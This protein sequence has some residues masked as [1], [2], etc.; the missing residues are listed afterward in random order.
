MLDRCLLQLSHRHVKVIDGRGHVPAIS[1]YARDGSCKL[2]I[3]LP[4]LEFERFPP[5]GKIPFE[6]LDL[7]RLCRR[8]VEVMMNGSVQR[9]AAAVCALKQARADPGTG[10]ARQK[11]HQD[12]Q[13]GLPPRTTQREASSKVDGASATAEEKGE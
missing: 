7:L 11:R 1:A 13:Q 9:S 3:G 5:H 10:H 8:Q 4:H 6:S 2:G 12:D